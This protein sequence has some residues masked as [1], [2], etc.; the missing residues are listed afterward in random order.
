MN[1]MQPSVTSYSITSDRRQARHA[2]ILDVLQDAA[3]KSISSVMRSCA[4]G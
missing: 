4:S 1:M 2:C 3:D